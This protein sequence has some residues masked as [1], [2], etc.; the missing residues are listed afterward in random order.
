MKEQWRKLSE[1]FGALKPREKVLVLLGVVVGTALVVDAVLFQPAEARKKTLEGRIVE[2]RQ[3]LKVA[4]AVMQMKEPVGDSQAV[5]RSYR[6]A[7]RTRLAEVNKDMVGLQQGMV[8]AERMPKL[9]EDMLARTR[10]LQLISLRA[11][12]PKRFE[13]RVGAPASKAADK[14]AKTAQ[15]EPERTFFQHGFELTLQG[16]YSE[17]HDYLAQLE[18][19]PWQMFWSRISVQTEQYPRLRVTIMVQTLSLTKAWL[20][21]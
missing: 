16:T 19:L 17:L 12:P 1:R 14:A 5:K 7:L 18:K 2:A 6:D 11:L 13:P 10:G 21:V 4:E 9:L 8:P 20:I 15:K 3:N